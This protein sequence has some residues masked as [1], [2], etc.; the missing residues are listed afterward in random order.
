MILTKNA[1]DNEEIMKKNDNLLFKTTSY[2][3]VIYY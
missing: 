1:N 2:I 3:H